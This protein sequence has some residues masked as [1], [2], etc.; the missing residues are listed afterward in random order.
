V[1]SSNIVAAPNRLGRENFLRQPKPMAV[2]IRCA[3]LTLN[4]P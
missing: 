2:T 1:D 4:C 3:T